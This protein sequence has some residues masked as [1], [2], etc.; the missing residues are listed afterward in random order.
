MLQ[1]ARERQRITDEQVALRRLATLVARGAPPHE[2]FAAVARELV[3]ILEV[4][5]TAVVR[6]E[7]DATSAEVEIS[8]WNSGHVAPFPIGSRLPLEKKTVTELV[9]QTKAPA[10]PPQ[11]PWAPPRSS[12]CTAMWG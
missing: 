4:Q 3:H 10:R 9:A 5:H 8:V 1:A 2:I 6:Y 12:P 11:A 7:P